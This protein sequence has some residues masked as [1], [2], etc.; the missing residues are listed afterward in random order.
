MCQGKAQLRPSFCL[1]PPE[2]SAHTGEVGSHLSSPLGTILGYKIWS[3]LFTCSHSWN[4]Q[5]HLK[6][7]IRSKGQKGVRRKQRCHSA[8]VPWS[9]GPEPWAKSCETARWTRRT[10]HRGAFHLQVCHSSGEPVSSSPCQLTSFKKAGTM[11][12][13]ASKSE[14]RPNA[15]DQVWGSLGLS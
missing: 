14:E 4:S 9:Q 1:G 11:T 3:N 15:Q 5:P 12:A 6:I 7:H 2:A 10:G 8:P 13:F